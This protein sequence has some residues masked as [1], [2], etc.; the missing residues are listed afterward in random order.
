MRIK[1][2]FNSVCACSVISA[3][4]LSSVILNVGVISLPAKAAAE[5]GEDVTSLTAD[6]SGLTQGAVETVLPLWEK[7]IPRR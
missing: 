7:R 6:F 2:F 5:S 3:L 1:K 4:I